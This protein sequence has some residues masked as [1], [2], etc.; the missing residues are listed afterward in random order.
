MAAGKA[1]LNWPVPVAWSCTLAFKA[2]ARVV[3]V[4]DVAQRSPFT[5]TWSLFT[6]WFA[7]VTVVWAVAEG[8]GQFRIGGL[9]LGSLALATIEQLAALR[10]DRS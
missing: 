6:H 9:G 4:V 7:S 5:V 10:S 8:C 3:P 1:P 2:E